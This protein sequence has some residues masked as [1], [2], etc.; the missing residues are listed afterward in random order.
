MSCCKLSDTLPHLVSSG[1]F[2][3]WKIIREHIRE[4]KLTPIIDIERV[5]ILLYRFSNLS[6]GTNTIQCIMRYKNHINERSE[7][8]DSSVLPPSVLRSLS[9]LEDPSYQ[10]KTLEF[11]RG[12]STSKGGRR[13]VVLR[14]RGSR[15]R[16]SFTY[17]VVEF[18]R[19]F[20]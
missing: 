6:W 20:A 17:D 18:T 4:G 9:S 16:F 10:S 11:S 19:T 3:E 5:F 14:S 2:Q 15:S 7:G 1:S 12:P 8:S 13:S